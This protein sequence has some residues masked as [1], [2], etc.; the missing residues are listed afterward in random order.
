MLN[1]R[2]RIM[3]HKNHFKSKQP[4]EKIIDAKE[5]LTEQGYLIHED[6]SATAIRIFEVEKLLESYHQAK[7]KQEANDRYKLGCEHI[8][9]V[10]GERKF[11]MMEQVALRIASGKEES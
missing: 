6:V 2:F 3:G 8:F 11:S 7:S 10:R 4:S 9:K 5:Y 1:T